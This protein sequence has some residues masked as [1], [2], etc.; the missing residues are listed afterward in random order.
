MVTSNVFAFLESRQHIAMA[1]TYIKTCQQNISILISDNENFEE[2]KAYRK[3]VSNTM[4]STESSLIQLYILKGITKS[5]VHENI[6]P[7]LLFFLSL[8][9]LQFS[10]W[11]A[12]RCCYKGK[13]PAKRQERQKTDFATSVY[14][15]KLFLSCLHSSSTAH[16]SDTPALDTCKYIFFCTFGWRVC[17]VERTVWRWTKEAVQHRGNTKQW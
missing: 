9:S 5:K 11:L 13:S 17:T 3:R 4:T 15:D 14:L 2:M 10:Y 8:M 6:L 7:S 16:A 1:Q 12:G